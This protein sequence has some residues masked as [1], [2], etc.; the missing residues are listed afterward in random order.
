[1]PL[2]HSHCGINDVSQSH[3]SLR[4]QTVVLACCREL[5]KE[6]MS[7]QALIHVRE[8]NIAE[9]DRRIADIEKQILNDIEDAKAAKRREQAEN[10]SPR[11][12]PPPP[13]APPPPLSKGSSKYITPTWILLTFMTAALLPA[14]GLQPLVVFAWAVLVCTWSF[15]CLG[16]VHHLS[17]GRLKPTASVCTPNL[18]VHTQ[19]LYVH[20][21]L[22]HEWVTCRYSCRCSYF[23]R[24]AASLATSS[25]R[26]MRLSTPEGT[27]VVGDFSW[28]SLVR[29][30]LS[31][32]SSMKS[33]PLPLRLLVLT[34]ALRVCLRWPSLLQSVIREQL[35]LQL[36][37][38]ITLRSA[39]A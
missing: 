37:L 31:S 14:L 1:M 24:F 33:H 17:F 9:K 18:H 35:H 5:D 21:R 29:A 3:E 10:A 28:I 36:C 26:A 2:G 25:T 32:R 11:C 7:L 15:I 39:P 4:S 12:T 6:L 23:L 34:T 13:P 30:L 16:V 19:V 22:L 8:R 38:H 20:T 27:E